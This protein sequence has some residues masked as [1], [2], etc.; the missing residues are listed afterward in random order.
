MA[1]ISTDLQLRL[2]GGAANSNPLLSLGGVMSSQ[3]IPLGWFDAITPS[4]RVAG[5][6]EFRIGYFY[7]NR[8]TTAKN[9]KLWIES[10]TAHA[11]TS[12]EIGLGTSGMNGTEP[13]I[14]TEGAVPPGVV[15]AQAGSVD[16]ALLIGDV[17]AGQKRAFV[18]RW[19]VDANAA[20]T[21]SDTATFR[22]D[23]GYE[24]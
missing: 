23:G 4:E 20:T 2:S 8:S 9:V 14:A 17:P 18:C 12:V 3:Q 10:N 1:T 24:Q 21:N 11:A 22:I 16:T 5:R 15:F 6:V 13:A 19:T 7:N